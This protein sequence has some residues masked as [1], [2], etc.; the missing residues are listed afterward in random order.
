MVAGSLNGSTPPSPPSYSTNPS[1]DYYQ[2]VKEVYDISQS[3]APAQTATALYYR[4]NP[5]Y[6]GGHYLSILRQVLQQEN[7][8]WILPL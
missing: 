2:M 5:G 3:L 7:P 1:S 4:D 8:H 6:G